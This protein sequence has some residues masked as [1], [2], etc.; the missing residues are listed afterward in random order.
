[1]LYKVKINDTIIRLDL[2]VAGEGEGS[3]VLD[4]GAVSL[5]EGVLAYL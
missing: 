2:D 5:S 3:E 4:V 1:M